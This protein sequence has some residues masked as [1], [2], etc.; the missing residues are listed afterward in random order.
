[1]V[2]ADTDLSPD[3]SYTSGSMSIQQS[4]AALRQAAAEARLI[5]LELAAARLGVAVAGLSVDDGRIAAGAAGKSTTYW[6]LVSDTTLQRRSDRPRHAEAAGGSPSG[7]AAGAAARHPGQGLRRSRLHPRPATPRD[8]ARARGAAAELRRA[9]R[10]GRRRRD[11][12]AAGRR[13]HRARRQLPR[14]RRGARGAGDRGAPRRWPP[15]RA[16]KAPTLPPPGEAALAEWLR[17]VPSREGTV[18]SK[19]ARPA[20]D[21]SRSAKTIDADYC[22]AVHRARVARPVVRG[23]AGD[24]RSPAGLDPRPGRVSDAAALSKVLALPPDRLRVT[25]IEGAGCY[26]HNGADDAACDAALIARAR[27]P[28]RPVRVQWSRQ[29]ELRWSP[30][31]SAMVDPRARRPRRAGHVAFWRTSS[32]ATPT[33]RAPARRGRLRRRLAPRV[34]AAAA[35]GVNIPQPAGGEDRN[36]VPL[37]DFPSQRV[38]EHFVPDMPVRVSA[39]R[40]L[41]AFANVF[42]IESFMDELARR[43]R[44]RSG[45]VPLRHLDGS[46]ARER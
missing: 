26:G 36:A 24:R 10:V 12:R 21:V 35:D 33:R 38:I 14:R 19:G 4:G 8:A 40:S 32:G 9:P 16:G 41:G 28:G 23:G 3:E 18:S 30:F 15:P 25:H 1:M 44:R 39:L 31:G 37:Y 43:R 11:A 45:R 2:P 5:L 6:E 29:D 46:R 20:A 7:R 13:A 22:E 34:T 27:A 17:R 42:A